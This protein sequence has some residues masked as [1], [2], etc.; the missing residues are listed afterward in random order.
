V[1]RQPRPDNDLA[2]AQT[3][4]E[5]VTPSGQTVPVE[6][7]DDPSDPDVA[8]GDFTPSTGGRFE[9]AATLN[10]A[11]KPLANQTSEFLVQGTDLELSNTGTNPANLRA[12]AE[13]TGGVYLDIDK[14]DELVSK[15][16]PKERRTVRVLRSEYWNNPALFTI[17]LLA[18]TGEWFLRRRNHLV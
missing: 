8:K 11:G 17:F 18:L 15:I 3:S 12:L 4:V 16:A 6:L 5:I 1:A 14:A 10:A 9:L 7:K 2:G 13:A